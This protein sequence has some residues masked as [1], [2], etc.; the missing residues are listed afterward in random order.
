MH[1]SIR[2]SKRRIFLAGAAFI[3]CVSPYAHSQATQDSSLGFFITSTGLGQGGDLG[4]LSGADAHCQQLAAVAGTGH[5][6]WKA[7][8][9]TQ[10]TESQPA[11][12]ARDR[13]GNGPWFNAD[14]VMIAANVAELHG[15]NNLNKQTALTEAG[16]IVNGRGDSP[17]RHD[18]ITGTKADGT[19]PAQGADSTCENWTS[20]SGAPARTLLG[21]HDRM[22]ISSNIDPQSWNQ[23][24]IS[25]GCSQANV[26]Q[27]GGAGYFYCFA[28]DE[29]AT[30]INLRELPRS[31]GM[32]HDHATFV[33][34]ARRPGGEVVYR[35]RMDEPAHI[36]VS[37]FD[38]E[39]RRRAVLARGMR[40]AG[41]QAVRW[42]GIGARGNPLPA[43]VYFIVL[44]REPGIT[45]TRR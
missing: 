7:Y 28:A 42:D 10:A 31:I 39:G 26:Q 35:F 12:N 33:L 17:S 37:V 41:S 40:G 2:T 45:G 25:S 11:V 34:E 36:E 23:A 44:K 16:A 4:G 19:A 22:G 32:I 38:P 5:R 24:H 9:S 1:A 3:L 15:E 13:I 30:G 27:G 14:K 21:H 43:G 29:Q 8:L 18:I 6:V 20:S